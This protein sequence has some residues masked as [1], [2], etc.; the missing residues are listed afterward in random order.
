LRGVIDAQIAEYRAQEQQIK[1]IADRV[2]LQA[3]IAASMG[4]LLNRLRVE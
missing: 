1:L 2:V 3:T 4:I